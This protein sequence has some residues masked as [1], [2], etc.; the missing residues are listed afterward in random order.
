M[1]TGV[2]ETTCIYLREGD[3]VLIVDAGT[4]LRR[5]LTEPYLLEGVRRLSVVLTHFHIDHLMG[6]PFLHDV[7]G[8]PERELWGPGDAHEGQPTVHLIGRLLDPPFLPGWGLPAK[9]RELAPP[10]AQIGAFAVEARTQPR[11]QNPTLAF[12]VNGE[13]VICTDTAYDDG[14][15]D[16][17]RGAKILFHEAFHAADTVDDPGHTAA[18]DAARIAAAAGVERLVLIHTNPALRDDDELLRFAR[19]CFAATVVGHDQLSLDLV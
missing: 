6:L 12:K 3:D 18:G 7:D 9:T 10:G 11:H 4:G 5:L 15:V 2:R 16:F 19:P 14:N 13:V 17:A 8:V 1:P